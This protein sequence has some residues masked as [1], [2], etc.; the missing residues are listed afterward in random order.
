MLT[1][2]INTQKI[3]AEVNRLGITLTDV[4]ARM[5]PPATKAA[6]SYLIHNGKNFSSI[7][8]I[9]KALNLD[10]KDLIIS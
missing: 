7:E 1:M 2:K 8:R 5:K 9:A 6:L 3:L 4:G 10:P